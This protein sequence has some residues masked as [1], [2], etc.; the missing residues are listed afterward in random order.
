MR[1]AATINYEITFLITSLPCQPTTVLYFANSFIPLSISLRKWP[2]AVCAR[3]G[4][5]FTACGYDTNI[6][7]QLVPLPVVVRRKFAAFP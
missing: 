3:N 5:Y 4:I 2:R 7:V 1:S 6:I